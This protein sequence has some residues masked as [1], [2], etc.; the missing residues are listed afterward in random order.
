M[1]TKKRSVNT[2]KT[3]KSPRRWS[4]SQRKILKKGLKKRKHQHIRHKVI[5]LKMIIVDG[6]T[7]ALAAKS[8]GVT[9]RTVY[10][11]LNRFDEKAL[12][13]LEDKGGRGRKPK[14]PDETYEQILDT[15]ERT[16]P[17]DMYKLLL[18]ETGVRQ[19]FDTIRKRMKKLGW[20]R[21]RSQTAYRNRAKPPEIKAFRKRVLSM[22]GH[23][24]KKGW[25]LFAMDETILTLETKN[26]AKFWTKIGRPVYATSKGSRDKVIVMGAI[27]QGRVQYFEIVESTNKACFLEFLKNLYKRFQKV[28]LLLDGPKTHK[29][30]EVEEFIKGKDI[31]LVYLPRA[32]PEFNPIEEYWHQLKREIKVGVYYETVEEME[33]AVR[34]YLKKTRHTLDL[35]AFIKREIVA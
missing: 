5:A 18:D 6:C 21:K 28:I 3:S 9:E 1:A 11:W 22:Y 30:E 35:L 27:G 32:I 34:D 14:I 17:R 26:G 33:A 25:K 16:T 23:L 24:K 8:V 29:G 10:N 19:H 7:V 2:S 31:K 4:G 12:F 20:S 13:G 15:Q